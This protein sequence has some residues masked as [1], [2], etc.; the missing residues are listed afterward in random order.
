MDASGQEI[1]RIFGNKLRIRVCG[2]CFQEDNILLVKHEPL[3]KKGYLWAPPGGGMIFGE[4]ANDCLKR[5]M[6]EETGLKIKV[7]EL[8]FVNEYIS[9]PLHA[10]ELFYKTEIEGG[11][12][13]LGSDPELPSNFQ[14]IKEVLFMPLKAIR[15]MDK[16]LLHNLFSLANTKDKILNLS[17]YYLQKNA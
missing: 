9:P 14:M 7:G 13:R 8:L 6:E 11:T 12:L 17:G 15:D 5:E 3:G 2:I 4:N 10:V 16:E 1:S